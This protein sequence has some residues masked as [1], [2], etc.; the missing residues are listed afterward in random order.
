MTTDGVVDDADDLGLGEDTV[1]VA[2]PAG[3]GPVPIHDAVPFGL[4]G[5]DTLPIGSRGPDPPGRVQGRRQGDQGLARVRDHRDGVQLGRVHRPDVDADERHV[6]ILEGGPRR[7]H[8]IAEAGAHREDEIRVPGQPVGC[9]TTGRADR[10]G[11]ERVVPRDRALAGLGLRD[12]DAE[13][14]REGVQR[15]VRL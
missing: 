8:E 4:L 3:P 9:Q 5:R 10:T 14:T 2:R 12:R 1:R 13:P 6:G 15:L 7:R 11:V